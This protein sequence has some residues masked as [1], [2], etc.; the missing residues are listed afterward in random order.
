MSVVTNLLLTHTER[1]GDNPLAIQKLNAWLNEAGQSSLV[2][3]SEHIF[4]RKRFEATV[5]GTAANY[6]CLWDFFDFIKSIDWGYPETV[7]VFYK[8]QEDRTFGVWTVC[9]GVVLKPMGW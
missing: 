5:M 6:L 2:Y 9:D 7:Q 4:G 3:V 8:E 1:G